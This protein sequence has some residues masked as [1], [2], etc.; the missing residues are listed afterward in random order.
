[1]PDTTGSEGEKGKA[2]IGEVLADKTN[3]GLG[4]AAVRA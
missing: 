3:A 4:G 2:R 1:M